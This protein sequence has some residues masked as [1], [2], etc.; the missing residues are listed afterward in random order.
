MRI[1]KV[2]YM[3]DVNLIMECVGKE[4]LRKHFLGFADYIHCWLILPRMAIIDEINA[5]DNMTEQHLF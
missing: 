3:F 5:M 1:R 2:L 4:T